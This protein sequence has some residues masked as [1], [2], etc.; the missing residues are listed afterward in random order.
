MSVD[1]RLRASLTSRANDFGPQVEDALD[2]VRARGR[3]ERWRNGAVGV[4]ASAAAAAAIVGTVTALDLFRESESPTVTR[5]TES[6]STSVDPRVPPLRGTITAEIDR[7]ATL[8]GRWALDLLG[9]GDIEVSAP[10]RIDLDVS[11]AVFTA[12]GTS[13]RT[14]LFGD[15]L[16]AG[17]GTG[18]YEWLRIGDRIEFRPLSDSCA[19]RTRFFEDATWTAST[20]TTPR[21]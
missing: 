14:S 6:A 8:A 20:A 7:P 4:V 2:R 16:C 21:G 1:D 12:D 17:A 11:R 18:I 9:N 19:A 10:T 3:R 5:P 15:D 13:F